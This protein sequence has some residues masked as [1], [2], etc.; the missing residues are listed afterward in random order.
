MKK[1]KKNEWMKYEKAMR[2]S[3]V[4]RSSARYENNSSGKD[5]EGP[6]LR[7]VDRR[8]LTLQCKFHVL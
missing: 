8:C 1:R 7:E 5:R 6:Q 2:L 4:L 3:S